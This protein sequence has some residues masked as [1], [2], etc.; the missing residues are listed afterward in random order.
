MVNSSVFSSRRNEDG[1]WQLH[2][3]TGKVIGITEI[4]GRPGII[5]PLNDQIMP[6]FPHISTDLSKAGV[7]KVMTCKT[8]T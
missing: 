5:W 7:K 1:R 3:G 6:G 4:Y 8:V 2:G